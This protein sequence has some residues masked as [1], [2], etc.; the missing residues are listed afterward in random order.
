M[1]TLGYRAANVQELAL[2]A[3]SDGKLAS[4]RH[5]F[6]GMT[7]Q[8]EDFQRS[9]VN[10]SS[11]L[12]RCANSELSKAGQARPE[13][14]RDMRAPGGGRAARSSARWMSS[15]MRPTSIRSSSG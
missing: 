9:F 13:H 2:A 15:P 4:F 8:F 7:S 6:V 5:E 14:A 10:W 1:F 11:L 3:D 12:Y